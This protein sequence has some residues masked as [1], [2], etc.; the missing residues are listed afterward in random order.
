[1]TLGERN[2]QVRR[3]VGVVVAVFSVVATLTVLQLVGW[4]LLSG[5]SVPDW[6]IVSIS[7]VVTVVGW[8]VAVLLLRTDKRSSRAEIR[9]D[10]DRN[11]SLGGS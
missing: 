9:G 11:E 5:G 3:T 2:H 1:M 10:E 7:A 6:P 4:G 8:P